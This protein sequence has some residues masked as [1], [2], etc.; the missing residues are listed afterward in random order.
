MPA[1]W[2][3][4]LKQR[5]IFS[6]TPLRNSRRRLAVASL[7]VVNASPIIL[8]AK[9][10]L[11]DLLRRVGAPVVIP[12]AAVREIQSRGPGDPAVQALAQSPWLVVVDPGPIAPA[13]AAR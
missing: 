13:V 4:Q 12:E 6:S 8:L 5:S 7:W 11:V 3:R 2:R 10:G 9:V 1:S